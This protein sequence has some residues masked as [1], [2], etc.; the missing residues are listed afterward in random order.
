M[1]IP[2]PEH[3]RDTP[4]GRERMA[5]LIADCA[6]QAGL[7]VRSLRGISMGIAGPDVI[8]KQIALPY[9]DEAEVG[10]ALRFEARKHLPFDPQGMVIDYQIVGR[11]ITEKRMDV[12]LAAVSQ[13]RLDRHVAPLR[14][15][16]L[17]AD[18]VDATPL[19]LTNALFEQIPVRT[20]TQ[21]LLDLGHSTSHLVLHQRTEP[22][23]ARRFEF[24]GK[25]L[26]QAVSRGMKIPFEEAEA[27]IRSLGGDDASTQVDWNLPEMGFIL[28]A[29]RFDLLEELRRSVAFYRTIGKLHEPF[30]V[31]LTGGTA[32]L[33]GLAQ[34]L[35]ELLEAPVQVFDPLRP[36]FA[37]EPAGASTRAPQ[38]TQAIGLSLRAA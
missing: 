38:Y 36:F 13:E 32:R 35:E 12:L 18:I 31:W 8:L 15:L 33:P 5:R 19:A 14:L 26:S 17:D 37:S 20:E 16:G 9:M 2:V 24:G 21:M 11:S 7:S 34:R 1:P 29:L 3:E 27:W 10:Q 25:S 30:S 4:Q 22:Y 28:D 23:F 6:S